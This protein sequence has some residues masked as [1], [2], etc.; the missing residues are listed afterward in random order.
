MLLVLVKW[1]NFISELMMKLIIISW[2]NYFYSGDEIMYSIMC[3][4]YLSYW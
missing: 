4:L 3:K 2:W 1:N